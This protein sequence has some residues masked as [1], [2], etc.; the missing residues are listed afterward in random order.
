MLAHSVRARLRQTLCVASL[1]SARTLQAANGAAGLSLDTRRPRFGD[2]KPT[3][4]APVAS[5]AH[6]VATS[7]RHDLLLL[8]ARFETRSA[9]HQPLQHLGFVLRALLRWH[10]D[11][12]I[13]SGQQRWIPGPAPPTPDPVAERG[14]F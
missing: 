9:E 11:P 7:A 12:P 1:E 4:A 3:I 8:L 10:S 14:G 13:T 5:K 6:L 2:S